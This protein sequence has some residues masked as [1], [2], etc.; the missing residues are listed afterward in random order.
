[1]FEVGGRWHFKDKITLTM[2]VGYP[3]VTLGVSFFI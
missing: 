2:R 3:F 1:M